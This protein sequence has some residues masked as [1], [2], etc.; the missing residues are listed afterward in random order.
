MKHLKRIYQPWDVRIVSGFLW[1]PKTLPINRE[2]V[3]TRWLEMATWEQTA[4][5]DIPPQLYWV[6]TKWCDREKDNAK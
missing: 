1:F 5:P 3:E 6:D 4:H 2:Q